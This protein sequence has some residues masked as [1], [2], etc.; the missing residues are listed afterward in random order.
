MKKDDKVYLLHILDSTRRILAFTKDGESAFLADEKTQD[1]VIRNF[2]IIGEAAKNVSEDLKGKH[3][4][5]EWKDIAG[6][7][8]KLIH[9]YFGVK[10]QLVWRSVQDDIPVLDDKIRSILSTL[11]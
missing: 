7:R 3:P 10:L 1:A 4:E 6:M 11:G 9:H 2:E 5:L 8:D